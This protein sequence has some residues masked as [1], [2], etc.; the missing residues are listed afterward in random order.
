MP[1]LQAAMMFGPSEQDVVVWALFFGLAVCQRETSGDAK[2]A[3]LSTRNPESKMSAQRP[4]I[5]NPDGEPF[6][7]KV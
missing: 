6:K 3:S 2:P 1:R 4:A 7:R 5:P